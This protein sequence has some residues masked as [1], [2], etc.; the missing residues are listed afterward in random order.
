MILLFQD[1]PKSRHPD[2]LY[3]LLFPTCSL[4]NIGLQV[5]I[6]T[7]GER[8]LRWNLRYELITLTNN[9]LL[10]QI[11]LD[12]LVFHS[13]ITLKKGNFKLKQTYIFF[14]CVI[15]FPATPIV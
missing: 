6:S 1:W 4:N 2:G 7:L 3:C 8:R 9:L 15:V 10:Q 11:R 5:K 13:H 14:S 12:K